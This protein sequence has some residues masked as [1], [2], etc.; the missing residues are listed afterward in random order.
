MSRRH[1]SGGKEVRVRP[2]PHRA[3]RGAV[4]GSALGGTWRACGAATSSLHCGRHWRTGLSHRNAAR[5]ILLLP[6]CARCLRW[7]EVGALSG[8]RGVLSYFDTHSLNMRD[9]YIVPY[10]YVYIEDEKKNTNN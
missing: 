4:I 8:R 2:G 7:S 10:G 1:C 5:R 3:A 6:L 9:T